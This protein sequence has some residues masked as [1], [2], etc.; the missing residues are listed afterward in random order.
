MQIEFI[1]QHKL[2]QVEL[3]R[4][5]NSQYIAFHCNLSTI[6]RNLHTRGRETRAYAKQHA[7]MQNAISGIVYFFLSSTKKTSTLLSF[8][9][10]GKTKKKRW[11]SN[12]IQFNGIKLTESFSIFFF[13]VKG[14]TAYKKEKQNIFIDSFRY[15]TLIQ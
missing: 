15:I 14:Y 11:K 8:D 2:R 5:V 6:P 1:L 4:Y 13:Y 12:S 10:L 9:L 7:C 3:S